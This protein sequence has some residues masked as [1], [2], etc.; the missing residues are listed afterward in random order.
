MLK[1]NMLYCP[2]EINYNKYYSNF[3]EQDARAAGEKAKNEFLES[4]QKLA[5]LLDIPKEMT[6]CTTLNDIFSSFI[7][8]QL[9]NCEKKVIKIDNIFVA[10]KN[11][12]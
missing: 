4:S 9:K 2:S 11:K 3:L 5:Q 10:A 12:S 7:K 8:N 1:A 6:F